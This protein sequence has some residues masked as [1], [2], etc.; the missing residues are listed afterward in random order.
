MFFL[1]KLLA[2]PAALVVFALR[3]E[4]FGVTLVA[5]IEAE[6]EGVHRLIK[7]EILANPEAPPDTPS[8]EA[9]LE[10]EVAEK[11]FPAASTEASLTVVEA[12]TE[13]F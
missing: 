3:E 8:M 10:A 6:E 13:A 1:I 9:F 4:L 2:L 11:T 7:L 12:S 5:G